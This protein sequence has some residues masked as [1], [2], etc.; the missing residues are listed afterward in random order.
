MDNQKM[1]HGVRIEEDQQ[2]KQGN[3]LTHPFNYAQK[4]KVQTLEQ[5][6]FGEQY[7]ITTRYDD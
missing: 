3:Y 2:H 5:M 6:L 4:T 7:Q 1:A